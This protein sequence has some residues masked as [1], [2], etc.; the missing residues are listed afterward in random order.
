M[1]EVLY[2]GEGPHQ[3]NGGGFST[4]AVRSEQEIQDALA[5][6]WYR[7][8]PEA[9]EAHDNPG[10][11]LVVAKAGEP[12]VITEL[13]E[14]PADEEPVTRAELEQ[15]AR[16]LGIKFDGRTGDKTLLSKINAA[17]EA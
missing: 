8:M 1:E 4:L 6:G 3:R 7:T 11:A 5:N 10:A 12:A 13:P 9:I 14:V 15:Q 16:E 17:L 2:K